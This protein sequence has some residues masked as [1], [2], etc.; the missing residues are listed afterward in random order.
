[1]STDGIPDNRAG[2]RD[3]RPHLNGKENSYG[4]LKI[5]SGESQTE[6]ITSDLHVGVM[7]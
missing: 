4:E 7:Q 3:D 5:Y 6:W 1:M 2:P